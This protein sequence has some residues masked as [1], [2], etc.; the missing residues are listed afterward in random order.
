[1][2]WEQH[3]IQVLLL[4]TTKMKSASSMR[5]VTNNVDSEFP[6]PRVKW[7]ILT[8]VFFYFIFCMVNLWIFD[9]MSREAKRFFVSDHYQIP[10]TLQKKK[11]LS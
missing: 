7:I 11:K 8:S 5:T 6:K 10:T 2:E 3:Y 1:M 4:F 9:E